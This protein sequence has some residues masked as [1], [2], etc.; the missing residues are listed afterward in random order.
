MNINLEGKR[1]WLT[2]SARGLGLETAKLL[3]DKNA[4]VFFGSRRDCE[5][6]NKNDYF[7]PYFLSE[8]SAHYI[9]CDVTN[10]KDVEKAYEN[11]CHIA[12]GVDVLINNAGIVCT[13][14]A[15]KQS[16]E[17]F[18]E[19]IKTNLYGPMY[20]FQTVLPGMLANKFGAIINIGSV[21]AETAFKNVGAYA[22][23]KAALS[24]FFRSA[25]EELRNEH[26]KI[27]NI[28]PGAMNTEIWDETVR[29]AKGK[30]MLS[31]KNTAKAIAAVVEL[32]FAGELLVEDMT[33]R[34]ITGDL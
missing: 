12:G 22:A 19:M 13:S 24:A 8:K 31:P 21:T 14:K 23:T 28:N 2:G 7:P 4:T 17:S 11:I 10:K 9:S 18:E 20:C 29:E 3:I 32:C 1:I 27:V 33:L 34:P 26:I 30:L 6:Y 15:A 25:R 5:Y 16:A